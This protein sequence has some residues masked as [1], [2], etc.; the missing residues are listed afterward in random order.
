MNKKIIFQKQLVAMLE[1]WASFSSTLLLFSDNFSLQIGQ[2]RLIVAYNKQLEWKTFYFEAILDN[3][4]V[5]GIG[6]HV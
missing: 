4:G 2:F 1:N 3:L 5:I 6:R